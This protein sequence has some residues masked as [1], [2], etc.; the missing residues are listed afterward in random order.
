MG[1]DG[2]AWSYRVKP[3][4]AV[5][6]ALLSLVVLSPVQSAPLE[7]LSC[8]VVRLSDIGWT[9][10]TA[11]TALFAEVLTPLGYQ[12]KITV[13]SVPVTFAALKNK[14]V[15][16]FLGNW[17]PS[18]TGDRAPFDADK[19]IEVV[20]A[21][22]PGAKY[23]LAVPDYAYQAGLRD[24]ADIAK[25]AGALDHKI[26][27]I[28]PGNDGNRLVLS[29]LS[30]DKF[31]LN[32]FK[33]VESSE[34]GMLAQVDRAY[35]AHQP[36]VF[37]GWSPH[38][39][40][41]HYKMRYLEGGDAVFGPNYGGATVYK[42][43]RVGLSAQCPNLGRFLAHYQL[44]VEETNGLMSAILDAHQT[45]AAAARAWLTKS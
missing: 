35:R 29:M 36:V 45:P 38:P 27:G 1:F 33:L 43:T 6:A 3:L 30:G 19:S 42:N 31:G 21:V 11:S 24:F 44:T 2:P 4:R 37:L 41:L 28:E 7:P 26:Y 23:T 18:Q 22:L 39:M 20:G 34:Q 8:K 32:D 12:P 16:I 40:N 14:D 9:D 15:D 17:M 10:V 5:L 13:L 25:F